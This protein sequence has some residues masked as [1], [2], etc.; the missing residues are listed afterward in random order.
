M[1]YGLLAW[2][3]KSE[4]IF[5]QQKKAIRLVNLQTATAHTEPLFKMMNHLKLMDLYKSKLLI[6]YYK[7]YRNQLP[8]Y[9]EQFLPQYGTSRYP[10]RYDGLH[11]PHATR[12]FCSVN[13]K[14]QMHYLLREISHPT[15]INDPGIINND[16]PLETTI[17]SFS[18]PQFANYIKIAYLESYQ[19]N[20]NL[21][22]CINNCNN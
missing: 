18:Q 6:L 10:L 15:N 12:E 11:M 2:G 16:S 13:A 9:F 14:Y 4:Q 20:C 1:N 21:Q 19:L 3:T 22:N 5:R 8:H 17:L 7:L